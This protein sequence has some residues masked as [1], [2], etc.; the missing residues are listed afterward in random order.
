MARRYKPFPPISLQYSPKEVTVAVNP[1]AVVTK[2]Q[3]PRIIS[4][5]RIIMSNMSTME[6]VV[7]VCVMFVHVHA[8]AVATIVMTLHKLLRA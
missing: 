2:I 8:V 3:I 7:A 1:V 6:I 4:Q 5:P